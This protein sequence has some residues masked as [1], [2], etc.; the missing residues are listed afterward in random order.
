MNPTDAD[1]RAA[2]TA[3][4]D[5]R[6]AVAYVEIDRFCDGC[7]Y[8]LRTQPVR[9]EAHTGLLLCRC[10]ECGAFQPARDAVTAGRLWLA[11]LGTLA[12][13]GWV[14]AICGAFVGLGAAQVG[15][16]YF[17][18]DE[19][20]TYR[21]I[22]FPPAASAST[23]TSPA[24]RPVSTVTVQVGRIVFSG[25]DGSTSTYRRVPREPREHDT[26]FLALLWSLSGALGFV[27][28]T[29]LAVCL[30]HWR[31][32]GYVIPVLVVSGGGGALTLYIWNYNY[33]YLTAWALPYVSGQAA[34]C[35]AGGLLGVLFGRAL[36]RLLL[37]LILPP[38]LR[39]ALAFLWR[40]DG[41]PPP[42]P[43]A[44]S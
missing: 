23:G 24:S 13:C 42:A 29:L 30:Y 25:P 16:S 26:A 41:R 8:N 11:R 3:E 15:L 18:L 43:A 33:P 34:L 7:G 19:L 20:T 1:S 32:W 27:L 40:V 6:P 17:P 4:F 37:T 31:R 21:L 5:G 14:L 10:P 22:P 36:A 2:A 28:A 39:Q 9:R 38:R 35:L 12:L 44:H